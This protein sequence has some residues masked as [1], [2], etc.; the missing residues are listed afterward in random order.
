MIIRQ[1]PIKDRLAIV[2]D[3]MR[4]LQLVA[5]EHTEHLV[6]GTHATK[7][8]GYTD[9]KTIRTI[10]SRSNLHVYRICCKD[11]YS[12]RELERM[13]PKTTRGPRKR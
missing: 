2:E 8:R 4:E 11:F 6:C 13:P 5:K 7:L 12:R 10:A 3:L 1:A 9:S